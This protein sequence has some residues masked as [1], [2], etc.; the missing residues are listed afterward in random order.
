MRNPT[1]CEA[2]RLHQILRFYYDGGFRLV[3]PFC[4]GLG[5]SENELLRAYQI[6]GASESNE[7]RG[8]KLFKVDEISLMSIID[9]TFENSHQGYNPNDSI[10]Q[11]IYC[12]Y[13]EK[14]RR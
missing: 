5:T 3:E 8:W 12:R 9:D 11:Q 2:I 1:I 4:Y 6:G 13:S 10:M 7:I 14:E